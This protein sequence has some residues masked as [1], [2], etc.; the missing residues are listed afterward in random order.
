MLTFTRINFFQEWMIH[1]QD[2]VINPVNCEGVMGRGLALIFKARYP[3]M[4]RDYVRACRLG[5]V[6][7]GNLHRYTHTSGKEEG[8]IILNV[9]T[10][11]KWK[12]KSKIEDID[13]GLR[14]LRD[15]LGR[16]R[17][18]TRVLMPALGCGLGGLPWR[19]VKLLIIQHLTDNACWI[20][21][22][23]PEV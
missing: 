5:E 21:C 19:D 16:Y 4:F 11:V 7:P 22:C 15:Q 8:L 6:V 17:A 3:S 20:T 23:E 18:G 1:P 13:L 12:D 2:V 10:K 9:P 14:A